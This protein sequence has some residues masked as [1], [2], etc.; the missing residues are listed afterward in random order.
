MVADKVQDA[1]TSFK[2]TVEIM[3]APLQAAIDKAV[4]FTTTASQLVHLANIEEPLTRLLPDIQ[5][6]WVEHGWDDA[7]AAAQRM[8]A[9][10]LALSQA[11][12]HSQLQAANTT[13][14]DMSAKVHLWVAH[15]TQSTQSS[16]QPSLPSTHPRLQL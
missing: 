15:D 5:E 16:W 10:V 8:S 2:A 3:A 12:A 14:I 9:G 1:I 6:P 7:E 4:A 11:S 13:S